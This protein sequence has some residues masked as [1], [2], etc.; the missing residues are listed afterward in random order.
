MPGCRGAELMK[1]GQQ[2]ALLAACA[3]LA[4][5]L[6]MAGCAREQP[7]PPGQLLP[8]SLPRPQSLPQSL[9]HTAIMLATPAVHPAPL[10]TDPLRAEALQLAATRGLLTNLIDHDAAELRFADPQWYVVCGERTAVRLR[11]RQVAEGEPLPAGSFMLDWSL[12]G[13]C[14]LGPDG[15]LLFGPLQMLVLRDDEHGLV[16]LVVTQP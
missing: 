11:G 2:A 10:P 15:P 14:P 5:A 9:P 16:P 13:A 7:L 8:Q 1:T 4:C 12:D 6:L 3:T